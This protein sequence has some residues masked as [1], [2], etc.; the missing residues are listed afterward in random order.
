MKT[1]LHYTQFSYHYKSA[2]LKLVKIKSSPSFCY[3]K[4]LQM[5][6]S[7]SNFSGITKP[8]ENNVHF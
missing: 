7:L 1:K 6:V 5:M 2:L 3:L 4:V 8:G